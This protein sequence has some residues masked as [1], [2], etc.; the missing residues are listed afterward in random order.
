MSVLINRV[1]PISVTVRYIWQKTATSPYYYRRRIPKDVRQAIGQDYSVKSLR[2]RDKIQAAKQ[3]LI[4]SRLDDELWYRLRNGMSPVG[5]REEAV[6][7]LARYD[8]E[9]MPRVQQ[10]DKE[11]NVDFFFDDMRAKAPNED[12]PDPYLSTSERRALAILGNREE[13]TLSDAKQLYLKKRGGLEPSSSNR[14]LRNTVNSAFAPVFNLLGDREITKYKR[15]DVSA[16]IDSG[17]AKGLKTATIKKQLGVVRAAVNDLIREYELHSAHN[18]FKEFEIP[19]LLEDVSDKASLDGQQIDRVRVF[20][21]S[22]DNSTTNIIGMLLDTG[23][24]LSEVLGVT[25]DDVKLDDDVPHIVIHKNTFRRLKSKASIRKIPLVGHALSSAQRAVSDVT[26]GFVFERYIDTQSGLVKNDTASATLA[27]AL[28][29]LDCYTCHHMRHTM[30]TRL[31]NA[32]V[33]AIR[34]EE[35]QGWSRVSIADQYGEQT[36]L[37]NLQSDLLKTL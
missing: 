37:K 3:I 33:P 20:V 28:K 7:L 12:D 4:L 11:L 6:A 24:R 19:N 23:S 5:V 8:L 32:D 27:K 30:R 36:A 10:E 13:F 26:S 2:T 21:D 22:K 35:I 1:G 25:L 14:K 18:P 34:A 31:R 16:L 17:L 9:A 29:R 15:V